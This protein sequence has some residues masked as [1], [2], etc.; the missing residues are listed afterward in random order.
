MSYAIIHQFKGGTKD[1][2]EA[3]LA[4][5]HPGDGTLPA[6]QTYH[7]AGPS[8]DGWT[9]FAVHDSKASWEA[10]RDSTLIPRMQ[11]GI[12]GGFTAPPEETGFEIATETGS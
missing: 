8:A 3:T 6:G 4:A 5:V 2:Y 7:A 12:D 11:K 1:Q 10:F 9:I